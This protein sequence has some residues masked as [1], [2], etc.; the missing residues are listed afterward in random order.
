MSNAPKPCQQEHRR[1]S[2][3]TPI[4]FHALQPDNRGIHVCAS[5]NVSP[6]EMVGVPQD[7]GLEDVHLKAVTLR[8]V[9]SLTLLLYTFRF[10]YNEQR[11]AI[12]QLLKRDFIVRTLVKV[13]TLL[14]QFCERCKNE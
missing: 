12:Q 4:K 14:K 2:C 3:G 7:S 13:G 1:T 9:L 11:Q 10:R 6:R 8:Q 5:C